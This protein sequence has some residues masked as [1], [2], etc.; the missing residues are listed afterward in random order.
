MQTAQ[1]KDITTQDLI[2]YEIPIIARGRIIDDYSESFGGRYGAKFTTPD[3]KKYVQKI[4]LTNPSKLTDLYDLSI[5][6]ILGMDSKF[7][8]MVKMGSRCGVVLITKMLPIPLKS[9]KQRTINSYS[10]LMLSSLEEKFR[11]T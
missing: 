9:Q 10:V 6:E 2:E 11:F 3:A 4:A 1:E 5:E 8:C 7:T